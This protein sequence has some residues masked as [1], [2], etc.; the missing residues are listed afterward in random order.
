MISDQLRGLGFK[1][2]IYVIDTRS[3]RITKMAGLP[4]ERFYIL[5][6]DPLTYEELLKF[7]TII[8]EKSEDFTMNWS[9]NVVEGFWP[10]KYLYVIYGSEDRYYILSRYYKRINRKIILTV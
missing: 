5:D 10:L 7:L 4:N 8:K 3:F 6:S 9:S 1:D 2:G